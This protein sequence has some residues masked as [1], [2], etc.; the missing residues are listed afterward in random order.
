M[1]QALER[2]PLQDFVTP[3]HIRLVRIHPRTGASSEPGSGSTIQI[4]LA[5]EMTPRTAQVKAVQNTDR[6]GGANAGVP[7]RWRDLGLSGYSPRPESETPAT[8]E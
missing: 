1:Q 2:I 6:L 8:S 7:S 3:P 4:A 5:E